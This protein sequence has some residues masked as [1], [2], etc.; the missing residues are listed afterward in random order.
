[1]GFGQGGDAEPG[2]GNQAPCIQPIELHR[3]L[4]IAA[5]VPSRCSCCNYWSSRAAYYSPATNPQLNRMRLIQRRR[6]KCSPGGNRRLDAAETGTAASAGVWLQERDPG[7]RGLGTP[8]GGIKI[9]QFRPVRLHCQ[10]R[11][12]RPLGSRRNPGASHAAETA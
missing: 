11:C 9:S 7:R 3:A 4:S 5:V 1:M 8:G 6:S 12:S 10:K 2:I